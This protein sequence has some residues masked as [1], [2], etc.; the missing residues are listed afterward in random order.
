MLIKNDEI[1]KLKKQIGIMGEEQEELKEQKERY[2][3]KI[4]RLQSKIDDYEKR[5]YGI[6][7]DCLHQQVRFLQSKLS[8]YQWKIQRYLSLA[9]QVK[10][11]EFFNSN[12]MRDIERQME[13][14]RRFKMIELDDIISQAFQTRETKVKNEEKDESKRVDYEEK[15]QQMNKARKVIGVIN[16]S[17]F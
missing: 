4:E 10:A 2:V 1:R 14:G 15:M 9:H 12:E 8:L 17:E 6:D 3:L 5:Y 7:L 13:D 16:G 11:T